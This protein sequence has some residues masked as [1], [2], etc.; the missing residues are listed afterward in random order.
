MHAAGE[1]SD[2][3]SG[4][5]CTCAG[6]DAEQRAT[7]TRGAVATSARTSIGAVPCSAVIAAVACARSRNLTKATPLDGPSGPSRK[8]CTCSTSPYGRNNAMMASLCADNGRLATNSLD[9]AQCGARVSAPR[10]A[11]PANASPA[12]SHLFRRRRGALAS[13]LSSAAA[14][15]CRG[16]WRWPAPR[17]LL[18]GTSGTRTLHAQCTHV[19]QSGVTV[20]DEAAGQAS[21]G[22]HVRHTHHGGRRWRGCE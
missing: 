9:S 6:G 4:E 21:S 7:D 16:T 13:T 1:C 19:H 12:G 17:Q 10:C 15:P 2:A 18:F 8:M 3:T 5:Q 22:H 20:S 11:S 14:S